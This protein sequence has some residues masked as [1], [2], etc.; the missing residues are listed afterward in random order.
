MDQKP[1][2]VRTRPF[3]RV[4]AGVAAGA[5]L[6]VAYSFVSRALGAT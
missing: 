5:A 1:S 4:A 6:G 2:T 3:L